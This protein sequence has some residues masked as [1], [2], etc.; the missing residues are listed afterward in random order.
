MNINKNDKNY[1]EQVQINQTLKLRETLATLPSFCK[2]YFRGMDNTIAA[3]TKL[4]YALD[5]RIF[6]DFIKE[7]KPAYREVAIVDFP[8]HILDE[9]SKTEVEENL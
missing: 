6:F 7:T 9:I 1:H 5:L 8:M 2:V 3:R 4:A